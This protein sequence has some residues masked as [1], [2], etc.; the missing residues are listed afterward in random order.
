MN[1]VA[2]QQ[3]ANFNTN[4]LKVKA[5]GAAEVNNSE[6]MKSKSDSLESLIKCCE[7]MS[8]EKLKLHET[9]SLT[10]N[11]FFG[12]SCKFGKYYTKSMKKTQHIVR[13]R[14]FIKALLE[15]HHT[16]MCILHNLAHRT[17]FSGT[18]LS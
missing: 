4:I 13:Y 11:Y 17:V 16:E 1:R 3:T 12:A 5:A 14:L 9:L 18:P 8:S 15:Q 6:Q 2:L 7:M 10:K